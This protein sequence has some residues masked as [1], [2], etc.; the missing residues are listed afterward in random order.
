MKALQYR[1]FG[2]DAPTVVEV[3][4]PTP[5]PGQVLLAVTAAGV[6]HSDLHIMSAS[7]SEYR[8]KPLPLTLGHEAAGIVVSTGAG[9]TTSRRAQR[10]WCTAHGG[11]GICASCSR[12]EE[13][14]C[15]DARGSAT[16]GHSC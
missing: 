11:C 15:T 10:Y 14:Y 2:G 5:G 4:R 12:G 1:A 6:C 3:P 16:S 9:R 7:P 8:Y 13:N